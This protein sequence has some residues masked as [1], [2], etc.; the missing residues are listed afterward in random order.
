MIAPE[1]LTGGFAAPVFGSQ[2]VFRNV[3][4]AF[5]RPGKVVAIPAIVTVPAPLFTPTAAFLC[6]FADEATPVHFE[7]GVTES[8]A[9][10]VQFHTGAPLAERPDLAHFAVVTDPQALPDLEAFALGT[11][12]YPDRST[13][14]VVQVESLATGECFRLEGPGIDGSTE[15][16]A[17]PMPGSLLAALKRNR[18]LFPRGVDLVLASPE[19]ILALPRS[20]R[21]TALRRD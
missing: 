14:I 15:A 2:A 9:A 13:T 10:W 17:A 20:T 4:D 6:T 16:R 5:A 11:Q 7:A 19:A 21:V 1:I 8:A 12:D 18:A 3:L